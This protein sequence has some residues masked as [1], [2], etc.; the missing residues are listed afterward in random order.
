VLTGPPTGDDERLEAEALLE[1]RASATRKVLVDRLGF[2]LKS[3]G[4]VSL[5]ETGAVEGTL[6]G[7]AGKVPTWPADWSGLGPPPTPGR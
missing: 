5:A 7:G 4:A 6:T 2:A 1:W 3:N